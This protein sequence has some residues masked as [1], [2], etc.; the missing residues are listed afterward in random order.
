MKSDQ[1]KRDQISKELQEDVQEI[2]AHTG[3]HTSTPKVDPDDSFDEQ[4][5]KLRRRDRT[6]DDSSSDEEADLADESGYTERVKDEKND[7]AMDTE[8]N[9]SKEKVPVSEEDKRK[10]VRDAASFALRTYMNNALRSVTS[11]ALS[12][13]KTGSQNDLDYSKTGD[14]DDDDVSE[15]KKRR[16]RPAK[17]S[18]TEAAAVQAEK[19]TPSTKGS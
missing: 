8:L 13:S 3:G 6:T 16:S 19:K 15:K 1:A 7:D 5:T 4:H 12:S 14:D 18:A 17:P 9:E 10:A 2:L 11:P